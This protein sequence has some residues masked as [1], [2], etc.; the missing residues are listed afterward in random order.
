MEV[1]YG[2]FT[3]LRILEHTDF[4]KVNLLHLDTIVTRSIDSVFS[5][6]A[7][8]AVMRGNADKIGSVKPTETFF[9]KS[10]GKEQRG[11]TAG[12]MVL[13]PSRKTLITC[14]RSVNSQGRR[15]ELQSKI[16]YPL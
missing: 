16:F 15:P 14:L 12:L 7:P 11:I 2:R 8:A 6:D 13:K 9:E 10:T 1:V 3:K 5:V 4:A